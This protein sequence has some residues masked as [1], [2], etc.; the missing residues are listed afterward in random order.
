MEQQKEVPKDEVKKDTQ[1]AQAAT[2]A[3]DPEED[4]LSDLDGEL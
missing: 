1:T 4:D 3:S 2:Y